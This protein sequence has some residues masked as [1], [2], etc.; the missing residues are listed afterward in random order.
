MARLFRWIA[1]LTLTGTA[2]IYAAWRSSPSTDA[3]P[4]LITSPLRQGSL[5][6]TI[7]ATGTIEP[8]DLIDVGA[9]VAG[10]ILEFGRD[11]QGKMIDYGSAIEEGMVLAHIDD[12]LYRSELAEAEA[13]LNGAKSDLEHARVELK[14][15]Q[16]KFN[17]AERDW[18]RAQRIGTAEGLSQASYDSYRSAFEIAET[19]QQMGRVAIQQAQAKLEQSRATLDRAQKNLSYCTIKSPVKGVI[20]DRRVNIG[21]T[22]VA[23]LSA[24]SLFLI[25]KDLT[26]VQIWVAVNEADIGSIKPGQPVAFTVD[27]FPDESFLGKVSKTRLNATMTNNVVTYTVEV[28]TENPNGRLLPYLTASVNFEVAR[29]ENILLVPNAALKWA[30]TTEIRTAYGLSPEPDAPEPEAVKNGGVP[31]QSEH[32]SRQPDLKKSEVWIEKNGA[33]TPIRVIVGISDGI[34]TEVSGAGLEQG[35]SVVSGVQEGVLATQSASK[36]P[37]VPKPPTRQN[38]RPGG[39]PM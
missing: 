4:G 12:V 5:V 10:R 26:R 22:V 39:P 23:S 24:P 35:M 27:A 18:S 11:K 9:Q 28:T 1:I 36:N 19:N 21:Q 14:Q 33:L 6:S 31:A 3:R 38:G 17:Q 30:P 37:F 32:G 20:I 8:E 13:Q 15:L 2:V 34:D 25:A 16:A 7:N 29:R